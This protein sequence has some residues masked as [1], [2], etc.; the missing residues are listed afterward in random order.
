MDHIPAW[1]QGAA[2]VIQAAV[3][4]LLLWVTRKYVRLTHH[5]SKAAENQLALMHEAE[6]HRRS[7]DLVDLTSLARRLVKSLDELPTARADPEAQRRLLFASLWRPDEVGELRRLA[8]RA[9]RDFAEKTEQLTVD[10]NW[11]LERIRPVRSEPRGQG[12]EMGSFAWDEYGVRIARARE[13]LVA[14]A[15]SAIAA[16]TATTTRNVGGQ[17]P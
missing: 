16:A 11:M 8:A 3:A 4:I 2:G 1:I 9:G 14:I 6:L 13:G 7:A 10:L 17:A 12:F 15:D 5:F